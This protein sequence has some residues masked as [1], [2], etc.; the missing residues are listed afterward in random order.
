MASGLWVRNMSI[1]TGQAP[2][3]RAMPTLATLRQ[4]RADRVA[5]IRR[6]AVPIGVA[7]VAFLA[8]SIAKS[9]PHPGLHGTPLGI[10]VA[11]CGFLAAEFALIW[12]MGGPMLGLP[13]LTTR[14]ASRSRSLALMLTLLLASSAALEFLQPSGPG[15]VGLYVAVA[16]A[17]RVYPR[18]ISALV[19]AAC[20][21]FF[22]ALLV[23]EGSVW[24]GTHRDLPGYIGVIAIVPVY[25]MSLFARR[26]REQ[27]DLEE[28]LLAELEESR[29]AELRATALAER[30]RLA[31]EMHDVLAHSL[32]GLVVQL[33]GTRL[34]AATTPDDARLPAAIDRAHQ[35]AKSGL[36]EAR[37]A[38]GMLRGD[39]LPGP[40]QLAELTAAFQADTAVP[41]RFTQSGTQRELSPAVRLALYRVTQEA[42]TNVRKHARPE[43]VDVTL[44]YLPDSVTLTVEDFSRTGMAFTDSTVG[45]DSVG[46][47]GL[48]G[49][50][51]RAG[52]LGGTLDAGPA[53][54]GFQVLLRVPA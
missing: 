4:A 11:A 19:F 25:L 15:I 40:E 8:I 16:F 52:L 30:Q 44:G 38:I 10:T 12:A 46:G 37:Q 53:R 28:R 31:R 49:M 22:V 43:R 45:R 51:E 47:Y 41:C 6:R 3:E 24:H 34:L 20:V 1:M 13:G 7:V 14:V 42:L 21:G 5:T 29:N 27:E 18:R 17:A 39:E 26:V 35:L 23:T 48:T 50:R 2:A 33:E 54:G 32:S 36:D 9:S